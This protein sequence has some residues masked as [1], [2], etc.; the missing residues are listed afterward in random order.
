MPARAGLDRELVVRAAADLLDDSF[1]RVLT[2][3]DLAS[4]LGVRAPSLY[5]HVDG[6]DD[7]YQ[8]ISLYS[9]RE[10]GTCIGR[11]AIGR[12]GEDAVFAIADAY[13]RF[14]K[15]R[16]NLYL[17]SQRAPSPMEETR[18]EVSDEILDV[19]RRVLA[20]FELTDDEQIHAMRALRSLIHGFVSL[21][22][23][24]GFGIP[25]D[26]DNSFNYLVAMYAT[27]LRHRGYGAQ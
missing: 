21:E 3:S 10:L 20:P 4:K 19:L 6:L 25:I 27:G 15:E 8:A 2:L 9:T 11:A 13:R 22:L 18:A 16:P 17:T 5:N 1:G 26:V 14:A 24:G 7:L 12:S 23:V